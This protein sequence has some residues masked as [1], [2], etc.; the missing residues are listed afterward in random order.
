M[1]RVLSN[2]LK[3]LVIGTG[4]I[5]PGVSGGAI[6]VVFGMYRNLTRAI[7]NIFTDFK[8]KVLYLIPIGLGGIIGILVFSNIFKYLFK[9]YNIEIRYLFIGLM[10][11]T[12]P[13]LFK[14]A[15]KN[16]F[17]KKYMI[18]F[19]IALSITV[20]FTLSENNIIDIIP[21]GE[22]GTIQLILYGIIIGFGTIIPG[23]SSSVILMYIGAYDFV[24]EAISTI[25]LLL[26]IPMGIGFGICFLLLAKVISTLFDKLY[27]FTYYAV[28]GF[29]LGSIIP[30]YPGFILNFKYFIGVLIM[31][32]GFYLSFY[33]SIRAKIKKIK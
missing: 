33:L 5:A 28:L 1:K 4:A 6:A 25:D 18:P 23:V 24:L 11:G 19:I 15:N 2:F 16:G 7:A 29:V 32:V 26:L 31:I 9:N 3:G 13:S 10:L 27:G 21:N 17:K 20:M 14:T 8:N 22:P 12:F 30:I